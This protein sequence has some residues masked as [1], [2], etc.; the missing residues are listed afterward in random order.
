LLPG[1]FFGTEDGGDTVLQK[2]GWL[3]MD[4]TNMIPFMSTAVRNSYVTLL[5]CCP[6][7]EFPFSIG[8]NSVGYSP[9]FNMRMGIDI[10]R[11]AM[12]FQVTRWWRVSLTNSVIPNFKFS[13]KIVALNCVSSNDN[14]YF[15][16]N[17]CPDNLCRGRCV[18]SGMEPRT[19]RLVCC[20]GHRLWLRWFL[21]FADWQGHS[22]T[23]TS[24]FR[25]TYAHLNRALQPSQ[26]CAH[27]FQVRKSCPCA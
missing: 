24:C 12:F 15:V 14:Q 3:S 19:S 2:A 4:Y 27:L 21:Q 17:T 16:G 23:E 20:M 5:I 13:V 8:L 25:Q 10:F 22:F 11:N 1:L 6:V 7:T 18:G 9:A 26:V